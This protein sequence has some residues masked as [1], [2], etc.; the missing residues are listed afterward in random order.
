MSKRL[1]MLSFCVLCV[2]SVALLAQDKDAAKKTENDPVGYFLGL[3]VGQQM[4][5]SGFKSGDID[6]PSMVAG[7]KDGIEGKESSLTDE[8]LKAT[9]GKIQELL[10]VRR[11]ELL[12]ERKGA[13][14]KYLAENAKKEGIKSLDDGV[15]YKVLKEG[16]G[17]SPTLTDTVKVHYTGKLINGTIF[18]SSVQRGEPATFRVGQ[19]IQGWQSALQKMKAGDKWMIYIPSDLAYGTSGSR[20]IG[21]NEVLVFEVELLEIQ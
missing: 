2:P 18:D 14:E 11:A 6:Y 16:K 13:G 12:K 7:F 9:Q 21:P 4:S 1:L 3:S 20:T 19:V 5:Q 17:D 10:Q 8:Q 15:Q